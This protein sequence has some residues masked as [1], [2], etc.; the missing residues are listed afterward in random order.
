[1]FFGQAAAKNSET[2]LRYWVEPRLEPWEK[3]EVFFQILET[4]GRP[5]QNLEISHDRLVHVFIVNQSLDFFRHVHHDDYG[6]LTQDDINAATFHFPF[7]FPTSGRYEIVVDYVADGKRTVQRVVLT[8]PEAKGKPPIAGYFEGFY[9][10]LSIEPSELKANRPASLQFFLK[11]EK[12][13]DV[14]NLEVYLGSEVHVA[15][16]KSD[17]L[18]FGHTHSFVQEDLS[19]GGH[20]GHHGDSGAS[21][22]YLG[23]VVPVRYTFSQ[24]GDYRIFAQFKIGSRV[25]SCS[26]P[27]RV[28]R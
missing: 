10:G 2:T 25:V 26:F 22:S 23:P 6:P 14:K 3:V 7:V 28:S 16:W 19:G 24:A 4:N 21:Q 9:I 1:M 13:D 8:V 17:L 20:R 5:A 12:G 11:D 27:V 15:V 18:D